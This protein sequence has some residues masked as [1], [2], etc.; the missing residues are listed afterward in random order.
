MPRY[1][2]TLTS[3][4]VEIVEAANPYQAAIVASDGGSGSSEIIDVRPA[5]GRP[6]AAKNAGAAK[7]AKKATK[8]RKKRKPMSAENRAKLAQNLVKARAARALKATGAKKAAKKTP[9]KK[10]AATGK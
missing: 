2:V 9:T 1:R 6:P 10:R 3:T 5:F 7:T 4:T 8:V